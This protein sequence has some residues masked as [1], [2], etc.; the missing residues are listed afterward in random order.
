MSWDI[1]STRS[2]KTFISLVYS[3]ISKEQ[4]WRRTR[5]NFM[6]IIGS[7]WMITQTTKSLKKEKIRSL[8]KQLLQRWLMKMN[9][10]RKT[11]N[12]IYGS[13]KCIIPELQGQRSMRQKS[14]THIDNLTML[15]FYNSIILK[16]IKTSNF[17]SI[18]LDLRKGMNEFTLPSV[19][20]WRIEQLKSFSTW[21]LK[22][23]KAWNASSLDFRK[24][25]KV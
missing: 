4:T 23:R 20:K 11:I 22:I 3:P 13:E 12:E 8:T 6:S 2:I 15:S 9:Y 1:Q 25:I 14:E 17:C 5:F 10:S 16:G 18:P 21:V 24:Y 7:Q 19:C